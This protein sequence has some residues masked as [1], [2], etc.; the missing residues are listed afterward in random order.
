M[1]VDSQNLLKKECSHRD[2]EYE[3]YQPEPILHRHLSMFLTRDQGKWWRV[4]YGV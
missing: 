4:L 2:V 1:E 3:L